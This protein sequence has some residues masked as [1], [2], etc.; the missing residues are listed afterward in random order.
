[1]LLF[2][3]IFLCNQGWRSLPPFWKYK[4]EFLIDS[5]SSCIYSLT[6]PY[7]RQYI[8]PSTRK[9]TSLDIYKSMVAHAPWY[10]SFQST[11]NMSLCLFS[12]PRIT[13]YVFWEIKKIPH[14]N[15]PIRKI[16]LPFKFFYLLLPYFGSST[17]TSYLS[18][19]LTSIASFKKF[20]QTPST[21]Y[22]KY[23]R[24]PPNRSF[25]HLIFFITI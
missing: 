11:F 20:Q 7:I 8:S 4:K 6:K 9:W 16:F 2:Y 24:T 18:L 3:Q 5:S 23:Q 1:M 13:L 14:L 15:P 12:L 25:N 22:T 17:C 19:N 10:I 21:H